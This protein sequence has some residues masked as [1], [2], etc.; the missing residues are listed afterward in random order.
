MP[1]FWLGLFTG[2]SEINWEGSCA[3]SKKEKRKKKS[4]NEPKKT[5]TKC[6]KSLKF[7]FNA[8]TLKS[9]IYLSQFLNNVLNATE[10]RS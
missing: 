1:F 4:L 9:L 3:L 10:S 8:V 5:Q 7:S 2:A 6:E